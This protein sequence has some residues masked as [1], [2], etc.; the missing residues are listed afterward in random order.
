MSTLK[1]SKETAE[2]YKQLLEDEKEYVVEKLLTVRVYENGELE[3]LTKWEDYTKDH[4]TWEK[5]ETFNGPLIVSGERIINIF[6]VIFVFRPTYPRSSHRARG[7]GTGK[8]VS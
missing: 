1:I 6:L 3:F 5:I 7:R 2:K 8:E 4:N